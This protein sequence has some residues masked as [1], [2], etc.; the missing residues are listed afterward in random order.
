[1]PIRNLGISGITRGVY[2]R[3]RMPLKARGAVRSER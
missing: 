3:G 1:M 2:G